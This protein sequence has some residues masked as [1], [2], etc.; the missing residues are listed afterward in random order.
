MS[1]DFAMSSFVR[2]FAYIQL[3]LAVAHS[4]CTVMHPSPHQAISACIF[5][6]FWAHFID[7]KFHRK[8]AVYLNYVCDLS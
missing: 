5:T 7:Q 1:H 4:I 6:Q 8:I 2:S 3:Q